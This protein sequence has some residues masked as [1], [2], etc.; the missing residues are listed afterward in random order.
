MVKQAESVISA[1]ML[2]A[3][4]GIFYNTLDCLIEPHERGLLYKDGELVG[5]L[6]VGRH[7][8]RWWRSVP[9]VR[10]LDVSAGWVEFSP[11]LW[12][13]VPEGAG[14]RVLVKP[15]CI[16]IITLDGQPTACLE[17]GQYILWQLRARVQLWQ[18]DTTEL[19]A[20]LPESFIDLV[21]RSYYE[22]IQLD[23]EHR[24]VVFSNGCAVAW[25]DPGRHFLWSRNRNLKIEVLDVETTHIK[26]SPELRELM[27][28]GAAEPLEVQVDQ[29]AIVYKNGRPH[30]CVGPGSFLMWQ[31]RARVDAKIFDSTSIMTNIPENCW[32]LVSYDHLQVHTIHPYERGLLYIDGKF[33]KL[34]M[35]GRFAIHTNHR[36]VTIVRV[37]MREQEFQINGQEVMTLDKVTIRINLII[38]FC[39]RD[40]LK[41]HETQADLKNALYSEVQMA[42]RRQISGAKL[43]RL[44]EDRHQI[45]EAM[46][47]ELAARARQWGVEVMQVD[48]K[49][50]ILP[51]EMKTLLNRVIEAEKQAE[52]NVILRR[53]ETAATRTK[54]NAA[55]VMAGNE[56]MMRLKEL[57]VLREVA[58]N[59]SNLT[60]LVGADDVLDKLKVSAK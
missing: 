19:V 50:I 39:V 41:S 1:S 24:G 38:K 5:W 45:R 32:H 49:D 20:D 58:G 11:E 54:A 25:L 59:I 37:D 40:A 56:T 22:S 7:L 53:E 30:A 16:G 33:E 6:D 10:K 14:E 34:M 9:G 31:L 52:A 26:S 47:D 2:E 8:L 4:K 23:V 3:T 35:E 15:D 55:K 60:V 29:L 36:D 27:P 12:S 18:Y 48:L 57:D 51:G 42:A 46:V 43:E 28:E 17:P 13:H 21:P 44:L